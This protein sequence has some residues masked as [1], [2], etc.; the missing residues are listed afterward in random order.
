MGDAIVSMIPMML[1]A[2][3]VPA[4]V[5][6]TLL[7]LRGT[8]G[9][10]AGA[11]FVAGIT[12]VRLVQGA[13]F[14]FIFVDAMAARGQ[15]G[16]GPVAATLL[17]VLGVLLWITAIKTL[18][19]EDDPDAPPPKWASMLRTASPAL[20]FAMGAGLQALA[21]KQW[22]FTLGALGMLGEADLTG[23]EFAVAYLVFVLVA[24][25]LL[26]LPVLAMLLAREPAGAVLERVGLWL[27][28]NNRPI[29]IVV[30]VIFGTYFLWKGLSA[31]MG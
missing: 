31:F 29:K 22:V 25:V 20:A 7:L 6:L 10:A 26:L 8:G 16:P 27:E 1:A 13:L 24:E 18:R 17:L 21:A 19:K 14:G 9:L 30:S 4:P 11:S 12:V 28:R 3:L 15:D 23:A 2:A 5:I